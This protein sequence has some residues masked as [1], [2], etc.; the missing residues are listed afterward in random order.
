[1][2]KPIV[3]ATPTGWWLVWISG[4]APMVRSGYQALSASVC[5]ARA[6]SISA[7]PADKVGLAA[8]ARSRS[9]LK[10][11]V[12]GAADRQTHRLRKRGIDR[13]GDE[14]VEASADGAPF[15][16]ETR[17]LDLRRRLFAERLNDVGLAAAALSVAGTGRGIHAAR[18]AD[19]VPVH[20]NLA[21]DRVILGEGDLDPLV[22]LVPRAL[23]A[24]ARGR[25]VSQCRLPAQIAL[26]P[27]RKGLRDR[28]RNP[29]EDVRVPVILVTGAQHRIVEGVRAL[30]LCRGGRGI[31]GR[32]AQAGAEL[33]AYGQ[34]PLERG[35]KRF[36]CHPAR[37]PDGG[38]RM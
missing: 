23:F 33:P 31:E 19:D 11:R 18:H 21:A 32:G 25:R 4:P 24:A 12:G 1:M 37:A 13:P 3:A 9:R 7:P 27:K 10:V 17:D 38:P 22:A 5:R 35:A 14:R 28:D 15:A 36:V 30:G 6:A 26:T 34:Q 2:L 8:R 16:L 29:A 20:R